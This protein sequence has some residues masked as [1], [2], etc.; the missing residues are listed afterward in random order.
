MQHRH[1]GLQAILYTV[2]LH[3][4]LRWRLPGY[5]AERNLGGVLYL[6]VR[7]MVGADTPTLRRHAGRRVRVAAAARARRGAQRRPRRSGGGMTALVDAPDPFEVRRARDAPGLLRAFND[8]GV[9]SV[10]DL[11]VARRLGR[12]RRRARRVGDRSPLALAVRG[13]RLG[14][15]YVDLA[16]I[17]EHGDRGDRGAGRPVRPAVARAGGVDARGRGERPRLRRRGRRD[18]AARCAS[19]APGCTSTA[20]G[21]RSARSPPTCAR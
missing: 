17:S 7:G 3:R 6:F 12:A 9:L 5:D 13:P 1:Y 8:A 21:A 14:H 2:A 11:H 10:A 19:S 16:T 4:Y 20:T 18:R 15:V